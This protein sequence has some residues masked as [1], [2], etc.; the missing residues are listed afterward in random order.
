MFPKT[1]LVNIGASE[2]FFRLCYVETDCSEAKID[3]T[4]RS[5]KIASTPNSLKTEGDKTPEQVG[6]GARQT[7]NGFPPVPG[8][9]LQNCFRILCCQKES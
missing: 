1:F 2:P 5:K 6:G 8:G 9:H 7:D 3:D 4:A